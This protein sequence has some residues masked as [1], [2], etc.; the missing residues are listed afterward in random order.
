MKLYK[1]WRKLDNINHP[2]K[3]DCVGTVEIWK[4]ESSKIDKHSVYNS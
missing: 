3:S 2:N 1:H 4:L